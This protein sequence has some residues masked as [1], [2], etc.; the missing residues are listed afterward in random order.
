MSGNADA[1]SRGALKSA[2][3]IPARVPPTPSPFL[4]AEQREFA[5]VVRRFAEDRLKDPDLARRDEAG[6]FWWDG[7]R[8]CAELGLCGLPAPEELGGGGADRVTIAAAL[9][10]L[11]YGCGDGGL[12]FSLSA[13][14]W[15]AVVPLSRHGSPEQQQR[16]LGELCKGRLIGLHAMTEPGSGSDAFSLR[17]TARRD[18]DG[19]ILNGRK[20]FITNAPTAGL[21]IVFA[22]APGSEGP[23]GISAFL[24]ESDADGVEVERPTAKLGLRTSPM[25]EI[26]LDDV[27]VPA[28]ALLGREGHGARIFSDSMEWERG[29]IMASQLG[30]LRRAVEETV[31]YARSRE[32]FGQPIASFQGVAHRVADTSVT[33]EA[34][35]ALLYETAR[36]YDA[37]ERDAAP[38]AAVK[39][40]AAETV[41]RGC[42]ALLDVHG[43]YGFTRE[44]PFERRLRDAVGGRIYSGTSDMMR[45][46]V[47]RS[48]GL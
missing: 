31:E 1:S 41:L 14:L 24:L 47:A 30:M 37:G 33:L 45:V 9:E 20:T 13:H 32:Q 26:A 2:A 6:E 28:S 40:F 12:V 11:G 18:T 22:R 38:A 29:L 39:L 21:F 8:R 4:S 5:D 23:L 43:G 25:A 10:S 27:R 36:R 17:T 42:V 3:T 48:L 19:W 34:A 44:L 7:W 35:R 46:M 16:W 15:S